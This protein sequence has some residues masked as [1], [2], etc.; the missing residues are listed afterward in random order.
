M[1]WAQTAKGNLLGMN[2][3]LKLLRQRVAELEQAAIERERT[4]ERLQQDRDFSTSVIQA[5]PVFFVAIGSDGRTLMM[6]AALLEALGYTAEEVIG[7]DYIKSFVPIREREGLSE[8]FSGLAV[9]SE[10]SMNESHVLTKDGRELLVEWHGRTVANKDGALESFFGVGIDITE[11]R[12][13][14]QSLKER[15]EQYKSIFESVTDAVLVFNLQGEI[16][17]AN[18]IACE[19]YDYS[20]DELIGLSAAEIVSADYFHGFKNFKRRIRDGGSF[21]TDSVNLRKDGTEFDIE[22]HGAG[23][24]YRGAPHLLSV[25]RDI[26]ERQQATMAL[27]QARRKIEQL[28]EVARQL[29]SCGSED[30]VYS[31]TVA[32]AEKILSFS[33]C[34]LDIVEGRKLLIKATSDELPP[35]TSRESSLDEGGLAAETYRSRRTTVFGSSAEA[36]QSAAPTR[37]DFRSGISAPISDIGVFQVASTEE[38][39]F[40]TEDVRLLELLLGHTGEAVHR[41]RLQEKL[42]EQALHDPLTGVYNRRYFNQVIE[43][44]IPRSTRYNHPIGFLMIDVNNFKEINDRHGHQVGDEVLVEVA[45]LFT[46]H[47]RDSDIV[48]RYGGDEFLLVLIET[49]G[50]TEQVRQRIQEEVAVRNKTNPVFD[51]SVTFSIGCAHWSPASGRA[52]EEVLA[53]ADE[54]MYESKRRLNGSV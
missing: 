43:Q 10:P 27:Q 42:R 48:V 12:Q 33:M 13:V 36:P 17:E 53:E 54:R 52:V 31:T 5:S 28:H 14:E 34:T 20:E 2:D 24:I 4:D 51:F 21:V 7:Q 26:T 29:E 11:R 9:A 35:D 40:S 3:E 8:I 30:D 19:M 25:V 50:E 45:K 1:T 23:F 37:S 44:E 6:N 22:M 49:N 46:K 39:A 41:I 32:A 16:V 47:V 18:P 15:E 38:N